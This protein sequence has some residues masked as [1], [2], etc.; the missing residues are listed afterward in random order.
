MKKLLFLLSN[1]ILFS[2][3]ALFI[4]N[5]NSKNNSENSSFVLKQTKKEET[6]LSKIFDRDA[7]VSI[8]DRFVNTKEKVINAIKG[9]YSKIDVSQLKI[10]IKSD[11]NY[12][13]IDVELSPKDS[14]SKYTGKSTIP[15]YTKYDINDKIDD[16]E[17][18]KKE[19]IDLNTRENILDILKKRRVSKQVEIDFEIKNIKESTATLVGNDFGDYYGETEIRFNAKKVT[20]SS[21]IDNTK[22][23][24][25][26]PTKDAVIEFINNKY[27]ILK[28]VGLSITIDDQKK[29]IDIT[30]NGESKFHGTVT[31]AYEL[32]NTPL[33]K[34]S[35]PDNSNESEKN[36][37][38]RNKSKDLEDNEI[39]SEMLSDQPQEIPKKPSECSTIKNE[40]KKQ[41]ESEPDLSNSSTSNQPESK[42]NKT[43]NYNP[44]V[45][46]KSLKSNSN[47]SNLQIP[48]KESS[49]SKTGSK[50]SKT[51]VIVG[52]TLGVSSVVVTGAIGSWIYFKKRK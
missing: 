35:K 32:P 4:Y 43:M 7:Y 26:K 24:L 21:I 27:P 23:N 46:D 13:K 10:E 30:S 20:L 49:N 52:S 1:S 17:L 38:R 3:S 50:G 19:T 31:L 6:D 11:K 36:E 5:L 44:P 41:P 22:I 9:K 47:T 33:P 42:S 45:I 15:C 2:L 48:N 18:L 8:K 25:L 28:N 37:D 39:D 34:E 14:K 12:G 16:F 29:F 51:G 40:N